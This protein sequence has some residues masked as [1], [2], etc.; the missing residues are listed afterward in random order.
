MSFTAVAMLASLLVSLPLSYLG[1]FVVLRRVTFVGVA[2]GQLASAGMA[3]GAFMGWPLMEGAG[4][5]TLLGVIGFSVDLPRRKVPEEAWIAVAYVVAGAAGVLLLNFAP[6]GE[7]D[8]MSLLFGNI[9]GFDPADLGWMSGVLSLI[10][11][12]HIL[13]FKE[14][15]LVSFD[16]E[17]AKVMGYSVRRWTLL[18]YFSLGVAIAVALRVAGVMLAF[19]CL[20]LPPMIALLLSRSWAMSVG[21][22]FGVGVLSSIIG[23]GVSVHGDLPTGSTII[24]VH[25]LFL[26]L[27][28]GVS[29]FRSIF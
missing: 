11:L 25:F 6:G 7:A 29:K 26:L 8:M 2:L 28:L 15:L 20:V 3:L 22:S 17:V 18:F 16:P 5:V 21:V 24:V 1:L 12:L 14:F 9:L 27:A 23:V 4:L 13:C 19:S 10:L